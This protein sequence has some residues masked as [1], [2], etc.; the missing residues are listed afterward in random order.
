MI[1]F[2]KPLAPLYSTL[3][4]VRLVLDATGLRDNTNNAYGECSA[5]VVQEWHGVS[6][7]SLSTQ[8]AATAASGFF[9]VVSTHKLQDGYIEFPGKTMFQSQGANTEYD[10][11]SFKSPVSD[12]KYTVHMV[13]RV[14]QN[15]IPNWIYGLFGNYA[16]TQGSKGTGTN[17]DDRI[18]TSRSDGITSS[19]TKGTAGFIINNNPDD[20]ITP[21]VP[22]VYSEETDMSQAAANRRKHYINGVLF[23]YTAVSASTAVVTS[24]TN[25]ME[26]GNIGNNAGA[27]FRGWISHVIIQESIESSGTRDAFIASL[28]PYKNKSNSNY[29][30]TVD[31]SR[32]YS[33]YNTLATAG[34]YYF[35]Q[36]LLQDPTNPN[37]LIE[38]H[39]N[40]DVHVEAD[41]KKVSKRTSTDGGRTW[42]AESDAFDLDGA[43]T[44]SCQDGEWGWTSDINRIHGITD[45]H[46][47]IGVAGGTNQLWYSYSDDG[48]ANW[49]H[50]DITSV[51][52]SDGLN[53]LRAHGNI[54]EGGDGFIYA[55]IY[56]TT[57]EDNGTQTAIYLLRKPTGSSVTWTALNVYG[58]ASAPI[59]ESSVQPLDASTLL[60]VSRNNTTS[61]WNKFRATSNGT[62][63][64]NDGAL[65]VGEALTVASP[66][67]LTKFDV[68]GTRVIALWTTDKTNA[69]LK[70]TYGKPSEGDITFD[71]DTK[72]TVIDQ[73]QI[74][75]Y[76]RVLH[77]ENTINAI[78]MYALEP[79][80]PT[81]TENNII[82]FNCPA[83]Q[84]YVTKTE[85]AI[86]AH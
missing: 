36:G 45:W 65:T 51:V 23:A 25:A 12:L 56:K 62:S 8:F 38:F 42:T 1:A 11:M 31:E 71:T 70:V 32:T 60:I 26:I 30:F 21:N 5:G 43:G 64:V 41:D 47:T 28:L 67:L 27:H 29:F 24:P 69:I 40:G 61:E 48:G 54:V 20:L 18:S 66:P 68:N 57:D 39:H 16:G 9:G 22:F 53:G 6:P 14:G 74:L 63:V 76:G 81:L 4:N 50:T 75:H 85:L 13:L 34:R 49:T 7:G 86:T 73:T 82:T 19:L 55:L 3:S 79:N 44:F 59:N 58:P 10:F 35:V 33:V 80:P 77:R 2:I 84:Y 83:Y 78:A 72:T 46:T 37:N 17:Y 52:P 15:D